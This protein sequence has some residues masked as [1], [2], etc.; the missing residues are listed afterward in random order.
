[1]SYNK[2]RI[3]QISTLPPVQRDTAQ[4]VANSYILGGLD[5]K[6]NVVGT[7]FG[8]LIS[9]A[10]VSDLTHVYDGA[11]RFACTE[12][13][14]FT[15]ENIETGV[16]SAVKDATSAAVVI[17]DIVPGI[18]VTVASGLTGVVVGDTVDVYFQGDST[19][20]VPGT[21]LGRLKEGVNVGKWEPVGSDI[22]KYDLFRVCGGTIETDKSRNISPN[23]DTY[24]LDDKFTV[25]V[26][27]FGQVSEA[28]CKDINLTDAIKAKMQ[29]IVWE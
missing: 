16:K 28:V 20:I 11:Y 6:V 14:K 17:T 29:G 18:T 24:M 25:D 10:R 1:M 4:V 5:Q 12:A 21:I 15:V 3:R 7:A 8:D 27:V 19:Y 26:Y 9:V 23:S 22:T 2:R 13:G